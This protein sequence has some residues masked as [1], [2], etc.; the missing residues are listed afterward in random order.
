MRHICRLAF[1]NAIFNGFWYFIIDSSS[2]FYL[3]GYNAISIGEYLCLLRAISIK[4]YTHTHAAANVVNAIAKKLLMVINIYKIEAQTMAKG[5]NSYYVTT[6][7]KIVKL[8]ICC[9][10]VLHIFLFNFNRAKRLI[11][12]FDFRQ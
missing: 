6:I 10:R 5:N 11:V 9:R 2:C 4:V 1:I 7:K 8:K 12:R 3:H